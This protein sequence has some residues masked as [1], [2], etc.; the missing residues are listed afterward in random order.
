MGLDQ[1]LTLVKQ[2]S[3]GGRDGE[4]TLVDGFPLTE[5]RMQVMD[6]RKHIWVHQFFC[7]LYE[8]SNDCRD[9]EIGA[10]ELE[11]LADKLERWIE[12]PEALQPIE[13][14]FRGPFFGVYVTDKDY[15]ESRD[16]Y[17]A[18]AKDEAKTIRKAIN[19]IKQTSESGLTKIGTSGYEYRHAVYRASW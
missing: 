11:V 14:R 8:E 18:D 5:Q 10:K 2:F 16:L 15:E 13:D 19:W 1:Y 4:P 12:D 6:W 3:Y 9:I 7:E 17:R